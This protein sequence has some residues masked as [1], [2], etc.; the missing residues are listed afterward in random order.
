M[1]EESSAMTFSTPLMRPW[2]SNDDSALLKA[3]DLAE[4][5]AGPL[6]VALPLKWRVNVGVLLSVRLEIVAPRAS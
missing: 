2:N 6:V 5:L 1:P 4:V 3:P